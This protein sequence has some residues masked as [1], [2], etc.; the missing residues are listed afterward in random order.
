MK[1]SEKICQI[2]EE[3]GYL[4]TPPSPARGAAAPWT[5]AK[6]RAYGGHPKPR[7][8]R[9]R[10]M[11]PP[12]PTTSRVSAL[13]AASAFSLEPQPTKLHLLRKHNHRQHSIIIR[14]LDTRPSRGVIEVARSFTREDIERITTAGR[15]R[16]RVMRHDQ[17]RERGASSWTLY[18]CPQHKRVLAV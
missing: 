5:P 18:G 11:P 8:A 14:R 17:A 15:A 10:Q 12:I 1:L 6:V 3:K 16:T 9:L 4:G 13:G 2:R 7:K